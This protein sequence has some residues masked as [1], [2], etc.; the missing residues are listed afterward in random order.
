MKGLLLA[1]FWRYYR[2]SHCVISQ[3]L[4]IPHLSFHLGV[5]TRVLEPHHHV[6]S[7]TISEQPLSKR[8][9]WYSSVKNAKDTLLKLP[10]F[11]HGLHILWLMGPF[12]LLIEHSPADTWLT[13]LALTF[14]VRAMMRRECDFLKIFWV[15]AAFVFW[16]ACLLSA[17]SAAPG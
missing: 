7:S 14:I 17:V 3:N 9:S 15:C 16:A 12:I 10:A 13:F 6:S 8:Y 2:Q 4:A 5:F 11:E 1:R